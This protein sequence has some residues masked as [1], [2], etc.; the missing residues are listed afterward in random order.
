M[1]YEFFYFIGAIV[2]LVAIG[3]GVYRDK[4]RNKRKDPITEAAT[5]EEYEHPERYERTQKQYERAADR[6][7]ERS[8]R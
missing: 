8:E 5:R 2:L 7:D 4:T 3:Y 1:G 6:V